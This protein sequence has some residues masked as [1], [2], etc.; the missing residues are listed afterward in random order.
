MKDTE[1]EHTRTLLGGDGD[2]RF[3]KFTNSQVLSTCQSHDSVT[4]V[5]PSEPCSILPMYFESV[6]ELGCSP[7]VT[8]EGISRQGALRFHGAGQQNT[9]VGTG[10]EQ[11]SCIPILT[12]A[13]RKLCGR[14]QP[15]FWCLLGNEPSDYNP[16]EDR[17]HWPT[18]C[19]G[20]MRTW[21]QGTAPN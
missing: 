15:T 20:W 3:P 5:H 17:P 13:R 8:A 2:Y 6:L 21:L 19:K 9:R 14:T 18:S 4:W 1:P 11:N 7:E 10:R 12:R 16:E